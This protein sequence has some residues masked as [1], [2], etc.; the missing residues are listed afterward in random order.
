MIK[1]HYRLLLSYWELM[2][3]EEMQY[4]FSELESLGLKVRLNE[5]N[6]IQEI[7]NLC[8]IIKKRLYKKYKDTYYE[9]Q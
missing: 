8:Q 9:Y 4:W 2:A 6:N 1:Q 5:F 3:L 7:S